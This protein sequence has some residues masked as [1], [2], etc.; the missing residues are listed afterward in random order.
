MDAEDNIGAV[1][2]R[3]PL[4]SIQRARLRSQPS[5]EDELDQEL[6]ELFVNML[7]SGTRIEREVVD[8]KIRG[9]LTY[10]RQQT[11]KTAS[12]KNVMED[13]DIQALVEEALGVSIVL[14]EPNL[15]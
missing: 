3:P 13:S 2:S 4:P 1:E 6:E 9:I 10:W 14:L 15:F 11:K 7:S 8:P 12:D 5:N